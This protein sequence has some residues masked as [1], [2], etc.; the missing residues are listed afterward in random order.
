VR[1]AASCAGLAQYDAQMPS[2]PRDGYVPKDHLKDGNGNLLGSNL[3]ENSRDF[4]LDAR[5]ALVVA[6]SFIFYTRSEV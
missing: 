3:V 2:F 4:L 1:L 6:C 5:D